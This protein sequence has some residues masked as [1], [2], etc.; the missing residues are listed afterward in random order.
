MG[1]PVI[2]R[3]IRFLQRDVQDR[4]RYFRFRQQWEKKDVQIDP[5]AVIRFSEGSILEIGPGSTIGAY[6]ILDLLPYPNSPSVSHSSLTIG[7]RVA[8]NEFNNI[9][10][11]GGDITIGDNC[12]IS[13]FVSIIGSNHKISRNAFIRDQPWDTDK[14]FIIIGND[15]WIGT[16]AIILPGVILG[17]GC[18]IAAG[19][20]VSTDITDYSIAAGIPARVI[21]IRQ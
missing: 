4:Y 17:Q 5:T 16:H 3:Y 6:S 10:V 11:G 21:G 7:S 8:I 2:L 19:A 9:R 13:Q 15:V 18:I 1:K 12:L 20:V 14:N